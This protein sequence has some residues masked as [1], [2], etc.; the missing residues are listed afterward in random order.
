MLWASIELGV[1]MICGNLPTYGPLIRRDS[2]FLT[3]ISTWVSSLRGT[4]ASQS[5]HSSGS[6]NPG[7]D[8]Y[9]WDQ[10]DV[11]NL[12]KVSKGDESNSQH[13]YSMNTISVQ[14][15]VEVV[16]NGRPRMKVNRH[17]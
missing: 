8:N 9:R 7:S 15:Q 4:V 12:T 3:T 1:A 6:Y 16:S 10:E 2:K 11:E 14:N 17:Y 5:A 13:S